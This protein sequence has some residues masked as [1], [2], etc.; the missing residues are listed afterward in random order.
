MAVNLNYYTWSPGQTVW[1]GNGNGTYLG[2]AACTAVTSSKPGGRRLQQ[3]GVTPKVA[4]T[5]EAHGVSPA[6]SGGVTIKH[7]KTCSGPKGKLC[8][9]PGCKPCVKKVV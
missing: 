1:H 9:I 6:V 4:K 8:G 2:L 3:I 5:F 7:F